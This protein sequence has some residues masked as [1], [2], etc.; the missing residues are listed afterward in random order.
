VM[1]AIALA[2]RP[3]LLIAD[4]PT[5]ALDVTV[6][7][8]I[9]ALLQQ[10]QARTGVAILLIS[11]DLALVRQMASRVAVLYA[12]RKVEE[13]PVARLFEAPGHPYSAG[14]IAAIPRLGEGRQAR[15]AEIPGTAPSLAE[16]GPGCAFA[17]RCAE[18]RAICATPPPRHG[19][20]C[21]RRGAS[22]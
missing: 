11:H 9:V 10:L 2:G 14:L 21:H 12:G 19:V 6:Q 15:L 16:R 20:A 4:E 18:A 22:A 8:Q 5:T 1:I 3:R 7:A 13:A 17:P